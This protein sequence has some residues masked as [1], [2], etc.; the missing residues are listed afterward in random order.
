LRIRRVHDSV[1]LHF[2]Y[3]AF[4]KS[5][6]SLASRELRKGQTPILAKTHGPP[7]VAR[8]QTLRSA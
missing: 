7:D 6:R 4:Q 2:G 5:E 1:C 3:V 8:T